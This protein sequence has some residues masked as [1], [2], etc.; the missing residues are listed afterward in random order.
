[1][2]TSDSGEQKKTNK[3]AHLHTTFALK[4]KYWNAFNNLSSSYIKNVQKSQLES[5]WT[6]RRKRG[7]NGNTASKTVCRW[8]QT[9]FSSDLDLC[10]KA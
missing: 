8:N 6:H 1:M 10:G 3:P 2:F 7:A 9:D 5:N 4:A